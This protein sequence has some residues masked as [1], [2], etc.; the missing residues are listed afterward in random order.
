VQ[1]D[2]TNVPVI[3]TRSGD[4]S[5]PATVEYLTSDATA[6]QSTDYSLGIGRLTFAPGEASKTI[7]LLISE[8]SK[9]EGTETFTITLRNVSGA[10][11]ATPSTATIQI[12]DDV[13]ESTGNALE[14]NAVFVCQHYHDFLNREP[15]PPG[16]AAW[17]NILNGCPPGDTRCDRIEVSSAFYR[18][19]EF[20][21]RGY[22][23]YRL[24][25]AALGRVPGYNEFMMDLS[26]VTGFLTP[27]QLEANKVAYI[28]EF[29]LRPEFFSR[30]NSLSNAAFVNTLEQTAGITLPNKQALIDDLNAGRKTRAE[31]LRAIS[32]GPEVSGK[33]FKEAFVVEAYF[34][35]LRREADI[36]YLNWIQTF[37]QTNDYRVIVNG[38]LNSAEYRNRFEP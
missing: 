16:L 21:D 33:F 1:E 11:L 10:A 13:P 5:G 18:S 20:Q 17:V 3:V 9:V 2:C 22:F 26:L 19:E 14:S 24:Y 28:N 29:M 31:V 23:V 30:Y 8:D 6:S 27:Q 38:F 15:E 32:Q 25:A 35:Y 12:T 4:A 7:H 36:L 37:N 34:G